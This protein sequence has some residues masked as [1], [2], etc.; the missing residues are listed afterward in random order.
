MKNYKLAIILL[1]FLAC[2][3]T[4]QEKLNVFDFSEIKHKAVPATFKTLGK[5]ASF[6][7]LE[8]SLNSFVPDVWGL[9]IDSNNIFVLSASSGVFRFDRDGGFIGKISA[10]GNGPQEYT[11]IMS[12]ALDSENRHVYLYNMDGKLLVFDYDGLFVNSYM[13]EKHMFSKMLMTKNTAYISA[14]NFNGAKSQVL[15]EYSLNENKVTTYGELPTFTLQ[16]YEAGMNT[17][18]KGIF[19][20]DGD[21]IVHPNCSNIVYN[22]DQETGELKTRYDFRFMDPFYPSLLGKGFE[23]FVESQALIDIAEDDKYIYARIIDKNKESSLYIVEKGTKY[24]HI[25]NLNYSDSFKSTFIPRYQFGEIK[26]D[27]LNPLTLNYPQDAPATETEKQKAYEFLTKKT[28]R[29]ITEESNPVL[30]LVN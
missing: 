1:L 10:K 23:G 7:A 2:S 9:A 29:Q 6:V 11:M 19:S 16:G 20:F 13:L 3:C 4:P 22:F 12:M 25:S 30:V 24:Y 26:A 21:L 15:Y 28:G 5:T 17:V 14:F 27:V 18:T 8:T